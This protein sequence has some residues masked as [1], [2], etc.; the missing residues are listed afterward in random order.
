M[1][2]LLFLLLIPSLAFGA[3]KKMTD[4]PNASGDRSDKY[5]WVQG[6][7]KDQKVTL[8]ELPMH[9]AGDFDPGVDN[10]SGAGYGVGS[11]HTN[12]AT[13]VV[14]KCRS[15]AAGAAVW[16]AEGGQVDLERHIST[17]NHG[18]PVYSADPNPLPK[19][20]PWILSTESGG[21]LKWYDG[22]KVWE[23]GQTETIVTPS[24]D[25]KFEGFG[26]GSYGGS[27]RHLDPANTSIYVVNNLNTSGNG[28]LHAC[29]TATGPRICVFATSGV[30]P[31]NGLITVSNPYL[32]IAGQTAPSPGITLKGGLSIRASNVIVQHMRIRGYAGGPDEGI[33]LL[34]GASTPIKNI[35]LDHNTITW[36]ATDEPI[37]TAYRV[38]DVTISN[39]LLAESLNFRCT[40][41]G[42]KPTRISYLKNVGINNQER[43]PRL[44]VESGVTAEFQIIN[45]VVF[46]HTGDGI[47]GNGLVKAS[48]VGN[49]FIDGTNTTYASRYMIAENALQYISGSQ[50]YVNDNK[51]WNLRYFASG[52]MEFQSTT[53]PVPY[54]GI[55]V[56]SSDTVE[57]YLSQRVGAWP[58]ARDATDTRIMNTLANRTSGFI[59]SESQVGGFPSVAVNTRTLVGGQPVVGLK[60]TYTFP[61]TPS[62]DTD[63]DGITDIEEFLATM[64]LDV[65]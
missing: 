30:I 50:L 19:N 42:G 38:E 37:S 9:T 14:W 27:G 4:L 20:S 65:E 55:E 29:A 59:T 8:R 58:G 33:Q 22:T 2:L 28:S 5:V 34:G 45:N 48:V 17:V 18:L 6:G 61:V 40:L 24:T 10:D 51:Y 35:I 7:G 39:N 32:T 25:P 11:R 60:G 3:G 63:N 41:F 49:K 47:V 64:A 13:G 31:Q 43:H 57:N 15:N 1:R 56:I 36:T 26:A 23:L 44:N 46:N 62:A 16:E 12:T 52:A 53:P 21:K 54:S